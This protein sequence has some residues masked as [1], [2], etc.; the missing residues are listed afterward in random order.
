[1]RQ[2]PLP[3]R[4]IVITFCLFLIG[5]I[6]SFL[7]YPQLNSALALLTGPPPQERITMPTTSS[8]PTSTSIQ[9][10]PTLP[11]QLQKP[12]SRIRVA[13]DDFQRPESPSWGE[14]AQAQEDG[15]NYIAWQGDSQNSFSVKNQEGHIAG[16]GQLQYVYCDFPIFQNIE[17]TLTASL[18][19]ET[20]HN[21]LGIF[22]RQLDQETWYGLYIDGL[23]LVLEKNIDGTRTELA[24]QPLPNPDQRDY[25]LTFF[26][27]DQFLAAKVWPIG[28]TPPSSWQIIVSDREITEGGYAGIYTDLQ[29]DTTAM[30]KEYAAYG[31]FV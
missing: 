6:T 8:L 13:Y 28:Q 2:N 10:L 24:S 9:T 16:T 3:G 23:R 17:H 30:V 26:R 1:M 21:I 29:P 11:P 14:I 5:S 18:P 27:L 25:M 20:Q 22:L 7:L 12:S 31:L 15:I 19:E 4:F